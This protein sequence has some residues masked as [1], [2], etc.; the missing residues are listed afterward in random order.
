MSTLII[1]KR[2]QPSDLVRRGAPIDAHVVAHGGKWD[3]IAHYLGAGT[4]PPALAGAVG[5]RVGGEPAVVAALFER[6]GEVGEEGL[7]GVC[8]G[9]EWEGGGE[10]GEGEGE[11][12]C[13][14]DEHLVILLFLFSVLVVG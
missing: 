12:E 2:I 10:E 5:W 6:G 1:G 9:V 11:E 13:G 14:W 3:A 4:A 7:G 8:G